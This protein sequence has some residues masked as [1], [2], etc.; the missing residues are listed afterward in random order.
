MPWSNTVPQY[1][2]PPN[3]TSGARTLNKFLLLPWIQAH[4]RR[5]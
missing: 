3:S 4:I 2:L 5:K 1:P